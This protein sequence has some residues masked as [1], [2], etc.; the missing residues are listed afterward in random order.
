[1]ENEVVNE[2]EETT[3]NEP[4]IEEEVSEE[5][6]DTNE[7]ELEQENEVQDEEESEEV[8]EDDSEE[9]VPEYTKSQVKKMM[10]KRLGRMSNSYQKK[11]ER[12]L[13][14][15]KAGGFEGNNL[16]ELTEELISNYKEEGIEIPEY[17]SNSNG[18]SDREQEA[19]AKLDAEEIIEMGDLA[20]ENRFAEL[21][22]KPNRTLREEKEMEAIG[23][24]ASLKNARKELTKL[25]LDAE[26][27]L[28]DD[29]FIEFASEM[30]SDVS[31]GKIVKYYQKI[32]GDLPQK[33]KSTGSVKSKGS[34]SAVK[35]FYTPE[36]AQQ[37]TRKELDENP[38]LYKAI[39]DS[40]TKW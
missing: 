15:L 20:M 23:R 13:S 17:R 2:L 19:L 6:E 1:M 26:K 21:Y 11:E 31:I 9:E 38:A 7:E 27:M 3:N 10:E 16:D 36:E 14:V 35:D 5:V 30:S 25:G 28:N 4:N 39:C 37:F 12:L 33:P 29:K 40:M 24:E 32:N 8:E 34:N 22:E 18:L